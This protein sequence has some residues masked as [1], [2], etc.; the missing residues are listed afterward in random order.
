MMKQFANARRTK[1]ALAICAGILGAAS[2]GQGASAQTK[3]RP[4]DV[5]SASAHIRS[6]H[7]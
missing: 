3:A 4:F 5:A 7:G 1:G 6:G 2:L